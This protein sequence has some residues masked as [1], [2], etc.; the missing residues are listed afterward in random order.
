MSGN[1]MLCDSCGTHHHTVDHSSCRHEPKPRL[2]YYEEAV[3]AWVPANDSLDGFISL[4]ALDPEEEAVIRVK[5][6]DMSDAEMAAL[7]E[8]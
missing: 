8:E 6:F 7:P 4:D 5:R 1:N 2:F 3:S